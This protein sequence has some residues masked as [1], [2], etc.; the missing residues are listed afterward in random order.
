MMMPKTKGIMFTLLIL[1][2]TTATIFGAGLANTEPNEEYR[3]AEYCIECHPSEGAEWSESAHTNA[4]SNSKFQEDWK[5]L[6]S[7]DGCLECH[8][9]GYDKETKSYAA[10]GIEC[11]VCHGPGDTMERDT[12]PELCGECHS[13]VYPTYEEWQDSGPNH[14][15]ADCITCHNQHTSEMKLGTP[16][17]TCGQCHESH[18]SQVDE[19][20]HGLN[21][22]G[23]VDCHMLVEEADFTTG[24]TAQTGHSFNARDQDLD[25]TSCHEIELQKHNALGEKSEACL[26]CHGD[27]HELKLQLVNGDTYSNDEPVKLC[28]QCHNERYSD[29]SQGTHGAVD[30]PQAVCSECHSPHIPIINNI[31]TLDPIPVREFADPPSTIGKYAFVAILVILGVS[32]WVLRRNS[33]V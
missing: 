3:G 8:V 1:Y 12:S 20:A 27:I 22:I 9:T 31:S 33:D 24:K 4:Y 10:P 32:V 29:W 2:I 19:S 26:S 15:S 23:C 17:A 16:D 14:G 6:G 28:A 21:G 25:C 11:E 18:V 30:D 5:Y 13:G 7:N